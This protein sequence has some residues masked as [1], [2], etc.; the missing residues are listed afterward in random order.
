ML[1]TLILWIDTQIEL[2]R[3]AVT[4]DINNGP[5]T[6]Y[7]IASRY[8]PDNLELHGIL[9]KAQRKHMESLDHA[10]RY[11]GAKHRTVP[12]D[13]MPLIPKLNDKEVCLK[14]M[15]KRG[16]PSKYPEVCVFE[17]RAHFFPTGISDKLR[18][19]I[20]RKLGRIHDKYR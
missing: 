9:L 18:A 10:S 4:A 7:L 19:Y 17:S 15:T 12:D 20:S 2:Y 6:R 1:S 14:F 16:C 8:T 5:A 13:T 11:N 3:N